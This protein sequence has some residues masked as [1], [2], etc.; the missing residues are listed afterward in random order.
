MS[1]LPARAITRNDGLDALR[2][3]FLVLMTVTHMPTVLSSWLGQPFG[4]VSAAEGFV[5]LS[6]FLAGQVYLGRGLKQGA[7]AMRKALWERA[8]KVYR[9]HLSLLVFG[10]TVILVIGLV[11]QQEAATSIFNEYLNNPLT[12][13][14]AG[15]TLVYQPALFDILPMYIGF[16]LLTPLV[17]GHAMSRGWALPMTISVAIW[18]AAQMGV[19]VSFY[20][21]VVALTGLS[22]PIEATGAF[23]PFAWQFLWMLGLWL[24]TARLQGEEGRAGA[25]P[26]VVA[27]LGV[28]A[29]S[30][31]LWRHTAGQVPFDGHSAWGAAINDLLDKWDLGPLRMLNLFALTVLVARFGPGLGQR[32]SLPYLSQLGRASLPVFSAHLVCCLLALAFFGPASRNDDGMG[33]PDVA[34]DAMLI[35]SSFA[36]LQLTAVLH[37]ISQARQKRQSRLAAAAAVAAPAVAVAAPP[38]ES[39]L[40]PRTG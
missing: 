30:F 35:I 17:L 40:E 33:W 29:L 12:T 32:V 4:Y 16:L 21:S 18:L 34:L 31:L 6:A 10:A 39:P 11:N 15:L 3:L 26:R 5:M 7:T 36:V 28:L 19:R 2:G 13:A 24:G 1:T 8:A 27:L 38:P 20:E 22:I 9:H 37:E 14:I 23:N 25:P